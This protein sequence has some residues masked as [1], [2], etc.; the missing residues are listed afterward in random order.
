MVAHSTG[1]RAQ[2]L[3]PQISPCNMRF[4]ATRDRHC[5]RIRSSKRMSEAIAKYEKQK[6]NH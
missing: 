4:E 1:G 5:E 3:S 2:T 6:L